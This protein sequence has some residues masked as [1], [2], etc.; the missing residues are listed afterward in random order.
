MSFQWYPQH[1]ENFAN[2]RISRVKSALL[3][4]MKY[5]VFSLCQIGEQTCSC[6]LL[7]LKLATCGFII[8]TSQKKARQMASRTECL[9]NLI[10][11]TFLT[12]I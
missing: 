1:F 9:A 2:V 4:I 5:S 12:K 10:C 3:S 11:P 7:M 8:S 6:V